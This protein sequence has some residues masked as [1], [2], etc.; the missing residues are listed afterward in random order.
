MK[1]RSYGRR[2]RVE[3]L[4]RRL[5]LSADFGAGVDPGDPPQVLFIRGG[6]RT[7]GFL[8]AGND[9]ARTEQ[10]A[11]LFNDST[12]GGNHGWAELRITLEDAGFALT[13]VIEGSETTA[14]PAEG[15]AL[16]LTDP[17]DLAGQSLTDYDAVVFGSNNAVY[18]TASVEALEDYV[19]GGGSAL[20]ISDANFGG[21]WADA[22]N[23]DQAFLDRF[24]LV[25]HQDQGTYPLTRSSPADFLVPDHPVFTG[26]DRI[27]GE[28]VTPIRVEDPEAFGVEATVLARAEGNTRLNNG[29]GGNNQGSSRQAGPDDATVLVAAVGEGKVAG[30]F[31]RNT[32][33][34]QNG[35]GTNINRFDNRQYALNLFGWMVGAFDPIPGDYD[36]N[37][38]VEA[39]DRAVWADAYGTTGVS[40]ADGNGD[41]RVDAADY[42]VWRDHLGASR[43]DLNLVATTTAT[44]TAT[45]IATASTTPVASRPPTTPRGG[46]PVAASHDKAPR[47]SPVDLAL[48]LLGADTGL[49]P[50][51]SEATESVGRYEESEES[52]TDR[53]GWLP[54][55]FAGF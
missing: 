40:A 48:L 35:A 46:S 15:I 16:D 4:E 43:P 51:P 24:G 28:G 22:S 19:R 25:A 6:D 39:A 7:G 36:G 8:E 2:C 13:Q 29:S 38:V 34:N 44:T 11:D 47:D 20:F 12:S 45:T 5:P 41:G 9:T 30:H 26:V 53:E 1:A 17:N 21:D 3:S 33:F 52:G 50:S 10:L 32:F 49:E 23:S 18:S 31:D 54:E 37:G 14:G 55:A 42:T 27:D